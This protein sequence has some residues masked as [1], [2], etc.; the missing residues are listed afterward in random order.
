[1]RSYHP[2]TNL[3]LYLGQA[4]SSTSS[5][6]DSDQENAEEVEESDGDQYQNQAGTSSSGQASVTCNSCSPL[7]L[8]RMFSG[9]RP[10]DH[11]T[12]PLG[13]VLTNPRIECSYALSP[14]QFHPALTAK[15]LTVSRI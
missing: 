8:L 2:E 3:V 1:M 15:V 9:A 4:N 13:T 5:E 6:R 11:A 10:L 7:K 14:V 12:M